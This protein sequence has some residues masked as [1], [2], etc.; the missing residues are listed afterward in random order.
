VD[1]PEWIEAS[2]KARR[3]FRLASSPGRMGILLKRYFQA[4]R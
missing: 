3:F 4:G 2:M 1:D